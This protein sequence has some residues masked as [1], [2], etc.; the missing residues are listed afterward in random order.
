MKKPKCRHVA[1]T[2]I[3]WMPIEIWENADLDNFEAVGKFNA[4]LRRIEIM[5]NM[6][7]EEQTDTLLHEYVHVISYL[8]NLRLSENKTRII[9]TCLAQAVTQCKRRITKRKKKR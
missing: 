5:P 3:G 1:D 7:Q 2:T 8:W 9:G 4:G 6:T